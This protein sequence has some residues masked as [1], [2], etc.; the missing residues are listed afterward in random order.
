MTLYDRGSMREELEKEIE[1]LTKVLRDTEKDLRHY[2][3]ENG[4]LRVENKELKE[5][6]KRN[7]RENYASN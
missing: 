1:K 2:I 4:N 3:S 6:V 7:Q 5:E